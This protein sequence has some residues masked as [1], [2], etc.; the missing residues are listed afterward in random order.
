MSNLI[1]VSDPARA[2]RARPRSLP[3]LTR[4]RARLRAFVLGLAV[5]LALFQVAAAAH[6]HERRLDTHV[7]AICVVLMAE[8]PSSGALPPIVAALATH[9]WRLLLRVIA[10]VC[11]YRRPLLTP[12]SCGPPLCA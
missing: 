9:S 1:S 2:P 3:V 5:V 6:R 10:Y 12:P 8:L 7:C 4:R 11:S